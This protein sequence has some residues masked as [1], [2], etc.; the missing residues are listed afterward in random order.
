MNTN[1]SNYTNLSLIL[2]V[3]RATSKSLENPLENLSSFSYLVGLTDS[4]S[5]ENLLKISSLLE[6]GF[7]EFNESFFL[8]RGGR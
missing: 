7:H 1:H 4:K 6:H 3:G 2:R 8:N 5:L